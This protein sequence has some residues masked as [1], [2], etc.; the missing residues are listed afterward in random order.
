M[1]EEHHK[2]GGRVRAER[3]TPERRSEIARQGGLARRIDDDLPRALDEGILH[4]GGIE[5]P[6]AVLD[7]KQRVLTQSGVM[8]AL[9]RARQAKGRHYYTGDVNLPAFL[10]AQNL[11]PFIPSELYVTSSQIEF[12]RISG[13]KAFGYPAELLPKVCGVFD[14]AD[15][16]GALTPAQK[17]I[18][19]RSRALLRGLAENGIIGL[20]DEATGYTKKRDKDELQAILSAY[21]SPTL[22]PW[23]ER[24]PTD[25]FKEMFRVW[26]WPWPASGMAYKGPL[27]PRYAGKLI[28]QV[29]YGNVPPSV[30]EELEARNPPNEK[31]QRKNRIGQNLTESVGHPLIDKLVSSVGTLFTISDNKEEFWRHYH[32]RYP[33]VGDQPHHPSV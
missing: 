3:L 5:I 33:K 14:D 17:H 7:T 23:A 2:R 13:G 18:A 28:K 15:L 19:A 16:A 30:L 20:V 1:P 26:G 32:R 29:I 31:W 11:K 27:G 21:L 25:F 9:G 4:L 8:Q 10:T 6:C 24:F 12:R 22:L